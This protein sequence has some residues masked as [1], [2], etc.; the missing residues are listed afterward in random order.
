[1]AVLTNGSLFWRSDVR[2]DLLRADLVLPTLSSVSEETF[3]KIQRPAPGIHVAQVVKGL[4]QF[5]KEYAGE[6]W[7][8]V[9]IIPGINTSLRELEGLRAAIE[10]IAPDRVQVNT[11]DRPGTE[12]W[13]RPASPAELE[14]IRSALGI[15]G[16][17]PVEPIGYELTAGA[18]MT[19]EWTDAVALV[20]ELIRRRPCTLDDIAIAT[21]LSRREILKILREIQI[22]SGIQES[23]EERG[24]FFFCPE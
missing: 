15:S 24:I 8:E 2:D 3:S 23:T 10:Q 12:H 21:G 11:L 7:L 19:P 9:F 6:I 14:R 4:I 20:R 5:R 16:L 18:P 17:I 22:S 1:M 13:V